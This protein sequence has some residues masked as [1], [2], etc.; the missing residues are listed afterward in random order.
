[1]KQL[2]RLT[3]DVSLNEDGLCTSLQRS[4]PAAAPIQT[5]ATRPIAIE[6]VRELHEQMA[7]VLNRANRWGDLDRGSHELLR[8]HGQL[9]F[10]ELL[11]GPVKGMLR[12]LEGGEITL[13]LDEALVFVPWEL[14]HTGVGF[15]GLDHAVGRVIRT[16]RSVIGAPRPEPE[17]AWRM[18]ILCDPRGDLM[19]SYLEGVTLR[20]ELDMSRSRFAVDLRGSE[21]GTSEVKR[22]LREYD[23][24]HFAGH[25]ELHRDRPADTGWL[26]SDGVLSPGDLLELAG[27]PSFPRVV[28]SNA[29]RSG[30][31]DGP[32]VAPGQGA[33]IFSLA[34]AF[35]LAGV[36]H[37]IGTLWDV[38]DEPACHFALA[39][40]ERLIAGA[41]HGEAIRAARWALQ[42]RYGPETVLWASY[43]LYG[44][45]A[46]SAFPPSAV[47]S[48]PGRAGGGEPPLPPRASVRGQALA[49]A[50]PRP[51]TTRVRGS[52]RAPMMEAPALDE[53][54]TWLFRLAP[55]GGVV[56]MAALALLAW[57]LSTP[58]AV[59]ARIIDG[60]LVAPD[61]AVSFPAPRE[62]ATFRGEARVADAPSVPA[63][64]Q[65][66][67]EAELVVLAE[68][69]GAT[70]G[71]SVGEPL[72][73]GAALAS[74]DNFQLRFRLP[75]AGQVTVWHVESQGRI[76]RVYPPQGDA[77]AIDHVGW[78][79][80]PSRDTFYFLDERPGVERFVLAWSTGAAPAAQGV[81]EALAPL[82]TE[83]TALRSAAGTRPMVLRGLGGT[84]D[85]PRGADLPAR[86]R[87][88]LASIQRVLAER[89]DDVRVVEFGHL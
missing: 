58:G 8:Q 84:R 63:A 28:F 16:G 60:P 51:A 33:A 54:R 52:V 44:D 89:Y 14:M 3:L 11:P 85:A 20:D 78:I 49:G 82:A 31:L 1:M 47:T 22:L 30:T 83:L 13:V 46:T 72:A 75:H 10:D 41:G 5:R 50:R 19:G 26:L 69:P 86:E 37:Y 27:G 35:L 32:L 43:V 57:S 36:R 2:H 79:V 40:Y 4:G 65:R 67:S 9:L 7:A 62:V 88:L 59:G 24:I 53:A 21:V 73:P 76:Q 18:L 61:D 68:E 15:L 87:E 48:A 55:L 29:C 34:S 74:G 66:A 6:R 12:G 45:P 39:Y 17:A 81:A 25:A 23:L 64:D 42:Q 77:A 70:A 71:P 56:A 80:L 38:P